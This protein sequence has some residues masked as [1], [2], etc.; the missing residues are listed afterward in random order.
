MICRRVAGKFN[1]TPGGELLYPGWEVLDGFVVNLG[2]D[3]AAAVE[4]AGVGRAAWQWWK[5]SVGVNGETNL[6]WQMQQHG[7][8]LRNGHLFLRAEHCRKRRM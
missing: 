6:C 7:V 5:R 2:S 4:E 3:L 8:G 1:K